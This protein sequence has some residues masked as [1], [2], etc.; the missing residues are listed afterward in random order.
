MHYL[1][2]SSGSGNRITSFLSKKQKKNKTGSWFVSMSKRIQL[3]DLV[4]IKF[5][6]KSWPFWALGQVV[7]LFPGDDALVP[8]AQDKV[9]GVSAFILQNTCTL[10]NYMQYVNWKQLTLDH[11]TKNRIQRKDRLGWMIF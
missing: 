1:R 9:M 2:V 8:S 4:I 6:N 11:L 3:S 5:P 7:E 10:W